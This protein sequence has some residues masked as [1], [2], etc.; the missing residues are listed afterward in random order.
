MSILTKL[1]LTTG[2]WIPMTTLHDVHDG[3]LRKIFETIIQNLPKLINKFT[4]DILFKYIL[5]QSRNGFVTKIIN[6]RIEIL[7]IDWLTL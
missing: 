5:I 3:E 6:Q 7:L 2:F 1:I 4:C